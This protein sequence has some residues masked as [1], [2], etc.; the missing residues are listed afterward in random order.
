M[1]QIWGQL[2]EQTEVEAR[3][4]AL[5]RDMSAILVELAAVRSAMNDLCVDLG[6]PH[7]D[8]HPMNNPC[9]SGA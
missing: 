8:A 4:H 1:K 6:R 9:V 7:I 2:P 5:E 3:L